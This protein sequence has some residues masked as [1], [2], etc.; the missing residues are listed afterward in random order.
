MP[1]SRKLS[2]FVTMLA[3]ASNLLVIG[4][5]STLVV[6]ANSKPAIQAG[7]S[8]P[9]EQLLDIGIMPVNPG[10]PKSLKEQEKNLIIPDV[11][12]GESSYIAYHL[13]N[14][15][16]LTGNWGAVRVT[17]AASNAVDIQISGRILLSDGESLKVQV[18]AVDASG[19]VWF[20]KAFTDA[21]S[22]FSYETPVEDPFQDLYND[23]ANA[24]LKARQRL[25]GGK[26][27][28]VKQVAD[29]KFARDLA[30]GAFDDYLKTSTSGRT[31]VVRLPAESDAI[32]ARVT[33]IK[34]QEYL[35]VDTLD[36][37]YSRF[38]RDMKPSYDEWRHATYDE[39]I[40]L[41]EVKRQARNRLIGGALLVIGGIVAS[42]KS[43]SSAVDT[44][45][46]GAVVGGIGVIRSGLERR[47][48]AEIHAEALK[49]LSHSL[50][51]EVTPYVLDIEGK[52]IEL[53]GTAR[54]QYA[55]WRQLLKDIYV[56]ETSPPAEQ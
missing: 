31:R 21:A 39:A 50:G 46:A 34:E 35:F 28:E 33:R 40:R 4:C 56:Q 13:K 11:R 52:T 6:T 7:E 51:A 25:S 1:S 2:T 12:R 32:M 55:Q 18:K 9:P 45:A 44:A 16:E 19:R 27:R 23:I 15:L 17:P 26:I 54:E 48:E 41:R 53:T 14:T 43:S 37:H 10:I 24:L 20:D 49:E 42:S 22:K 8:I 38:Y 47:K 30:P 29:L 3:L 36:D 5:S